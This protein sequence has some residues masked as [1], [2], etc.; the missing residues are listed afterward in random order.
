MPTVDFIIGN[1]T[2]STTGA[3]DRPSLSNIW[4]QLSASSPWV[5][6]GVPQSNRSRL[7]NSMLEWVPH[8]FDTSFKP[9]LN[10][11]R[12]NLVVS[13]S[14]PSQLHPIWR[15]IG[16]QSLLPHLGHR[17]RS[18]HVPTWGVGATHIHR[19][20]TKTRAEILCHRRRKLYAMWQ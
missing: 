16:H 19:R 10:V 13:L 3:D 4:T 6:V 11:I 17:E 5:F 20:K 7:F 8:R 14:T 15:F 1:P 9:P 18:K 12:G 2:S